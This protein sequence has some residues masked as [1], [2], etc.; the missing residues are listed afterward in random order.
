MGCFVIQQK[1][2][3]EVNYIF[4]TPI[5]T[6]L[7]SLILYHSHTNLFLIPCTHQ[8]Q[9]VLAVPST[10]NAHSSDSCMA[11]LLTSYK[12]FLKCLFLNEAYLIKNGSLP[13]G[14]SIS[15]TQ[16]CH[17]YSPSPTYSSLI[18]GLYLLLSSSTRTWAAWGQ[19]ICL[20]CSLIY[21]PSPS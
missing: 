12:P 15:L 13:P 14:L 1:I 5:P 3:E 11:N 4:D 9:S 6:T 19:R 21:I 20:Y 17:F 10:G 18:I 16:F 8:E 2:N 7:L